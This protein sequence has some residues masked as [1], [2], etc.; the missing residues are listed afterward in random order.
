MNIFIKRKNENKNE[1]E[2]FILDN[3]DKIT[4]LDALDNIKEN[5]DNGLTFRSGCKS[6]VCGTCSVRVNGVE[7]LACKTNIKENDYIEPLKNLTIIKDLVVDLDNQEALITRTNS[8]IKSY[9]F[10]KID[11]EA[12]KIIDT[13]S[14][15]IL[16]NLCFS[17]CPIYEVNKDFIGPYALTRNYRYFEEKKEND[18]ISKLKAIQEDGIWDCTLCGNCTFVCPQHINSKNDILK[19][20][21]KSVQNGFEDKSMKNNDFNNSFNN[22]SNFDFGFNPNSF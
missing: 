12:I 18:K 10:T 19:L 13:Q 4:V 5:Q 16:C 1:K 11:K 2:K 22:S 9:N 8:F 17:V 21:M 3:I 7:T 15:C 20:R 14:N 6:G